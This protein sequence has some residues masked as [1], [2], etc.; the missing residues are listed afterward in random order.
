LYGESEALATVHGAS[1]QARYAHTYPA[2]PF[3]RASACR[4][5]GADIAQR[6]RGALCSSLQLAAFVCR[7]HP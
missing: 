5:L 6:W 3:P 2:L 1:R 4:M 7:P